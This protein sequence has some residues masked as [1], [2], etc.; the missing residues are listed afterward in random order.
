[1][2]DGLIKHVLDPIWEAAATPLV[3][4]RVTPNQVTLAGLGLITLASLAYLWHQN[5][6]WY[7]LTLALAFAFDALDGA[8]ARRRGLQSRAGGYLDAMIDR[9]QELIVLAAIAWQHEVWGLALA[10]FSGS[11]LTSYAKARTALE[12][13]ISNDGWPDLMERLERIIFLC[14]LLVFV[15]VLSWIDLP[16]RVPMILGLLILAGLTHAT[17]LQRFWRAYR[18]LAERDAQDRA[19][20]AQQD[21][22][23]DQIGEIE[24]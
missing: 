10:V 5:P 19:A 14:C 13:E 4:A 21:R 8:V 12:V 6:I 9:Y 16:E 2:I 17:A 20:A 11:V 24:R 3:K 7:G 23:I 15:G 22:D 1:M 18:M